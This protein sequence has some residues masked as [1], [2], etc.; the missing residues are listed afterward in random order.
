MF[1]QGCLHLAVGRYRQCLLQRPGFSLCTA[2]AI[3]NTALLFQRMNNVD[4]E[5]E[6]RTLLL[7]VCMSLC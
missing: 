7:K 4:A 6:A 2:P 3:I 1:E 5:L